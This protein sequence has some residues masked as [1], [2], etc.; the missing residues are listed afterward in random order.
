[1]CSAQTITFFQLCISQSEFLAF[2]SVLLSHYGSARKIQELSTGASDCLNCFIL[3]TKG[4]ANTNFKRNA[5]K[6]LGWANE[7]DLHHRER[8]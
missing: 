4:K 2:L 8:I 1:M 3:S 5:A 6:C 7:G